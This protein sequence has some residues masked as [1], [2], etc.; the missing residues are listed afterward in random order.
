[1][2]YNHYLAVP[3]SLLASAGVQMLARNAVPQGLQSDNLVNSSVQNKEKI[4]NR[5]V[6]LAV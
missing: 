2:E 5:S 1:M 4:S 3:L 6:K